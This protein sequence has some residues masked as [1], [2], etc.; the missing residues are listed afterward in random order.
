M[1]MA[2]VADPIACEGINVEDKDNILFAESAEEYVKSIKKVLTQNE[3]RE[4]LQKNARLLAT[5]EYSYGE[6]GKKLSSLFTQYQKR[7]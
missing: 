2:I 6:I 5:N 7:N 3:L 1:G 4:N